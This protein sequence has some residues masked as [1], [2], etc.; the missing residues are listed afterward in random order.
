MS[1]ILSNH[2]ISGV[3][4]GVCTP[5]R[6]VIYVP[7]ASSD[8]FLA[9]ILH[10]SGLIFLVLLL[11]VA[12]PLFYFGVKYYTNKKHDLYTDLGSI[13]MAVVYTMVFYNIL[14]CCSYLPVLGSQLPFTG[15]S[16][17]YSILSSFLLGAITY[18]NETVRGFIDRLKGGLEHIPA[19]DSAVKDKG[20][21][22]YYYADPTLPTDESGGGI[23]FYDK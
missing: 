5:K 16:I 23:N 10:Y 13:S 3:C 21:Y 4:T 6:K 17:T 11:A 20:S 2:K 7:E 12:I 9:T 18:S 22:S 1:R 8:F 19:D 15:V 14:M